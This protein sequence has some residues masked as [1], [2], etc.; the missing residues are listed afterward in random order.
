LPMLATLPLQKNPGE[1][2]NMRRLTFAA[3]AVAGL[4]AALPG[5]AYAQA[6]YPD[7]PIKVVVPAAAGGVTD[8]PARIPTS[9]PACWRMR[10]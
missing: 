5:A 10:K 6:T 8:I 2:N 3:A 7:R 9:R 1:G 4:F